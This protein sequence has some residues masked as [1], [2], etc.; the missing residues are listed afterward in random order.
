MAGVGFSGANPLPLP[1]SREGRGDFVR[2]P[3]SAP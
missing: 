1:P 2:L 3:D